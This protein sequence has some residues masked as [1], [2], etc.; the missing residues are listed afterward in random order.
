MAMQVALD[1]RV[2]TGPG[3]AYLRSSPTPSHLWTFDFLICRVVGDGCRPLIPLLWATASARSYR[4]WSWG[5]LA[6]AADQNEAG[7]ED[8]SGLAQER[9]SGNGETT[10][11]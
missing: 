5:R 9:Q 11:R 6:V 8:D 4:C 1:F 2:S 3:T 7:D 10:S